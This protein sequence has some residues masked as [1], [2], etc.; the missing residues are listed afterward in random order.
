MQEFKTTIDADILAKMDETK[1]LFSN[2]REED[3]VINDEASYD[4]AVDMLKEE[5]AS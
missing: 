3:L 4:Y 5:P 2:A 1:E